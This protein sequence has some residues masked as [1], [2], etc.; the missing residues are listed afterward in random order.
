MQSNII[1][2][3]NI[4]FY[5]KIYTEKIEN[6]SSLEEYIELVYIFQKGIKFYV[7]IIQTTFWVYNIIKLEINNQN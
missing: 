7:K 5:I 6:I 1:N 3:I 2:N 4:M